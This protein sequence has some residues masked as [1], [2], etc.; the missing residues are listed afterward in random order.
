MSQTPQLN[1]RRF[2]DMNMSEKAAF[3]GKAL[4]FFISGG[5]IFPTLWVD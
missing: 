3:I 1:D 4:I 5:F 2:K